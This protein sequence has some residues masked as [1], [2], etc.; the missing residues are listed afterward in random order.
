MYIDPNTGGVIFQVLA[1]ILVAG[2]GILMVFS[3]NIREAIAKLRRKVR[4][5]DEPEQ[6]DK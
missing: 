1:G 5:E 3:R 2:S 4:K 6:Q